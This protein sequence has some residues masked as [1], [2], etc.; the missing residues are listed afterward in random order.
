MLG[1]PA[2]GRATANVDDVLK[3]AAAACGEEG[4]AFPIEGKKHLAAN[5][6][7]FVAA[8]AYEM[9][10]TGHGFTADA[11]FTTITE[12][13]YRGATV[14][15]GW[16]LGAMLYE[17]NALP[18]H[19][20][21][22]ATRNHPRSGGLFLYEESPAGGGL[23]NAVHAGAAALAAAAAFAAAFRR[24]RGNVDPE[25]FPAPVPPASI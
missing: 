7:C 16:Q 12:T 3:A 19:Y 2:T 17:I 13:T 21:P 22:N 5:E 1:L 6:L 9:F 15:V 20:E 18:W 10:V 14:S 25:H 24:K 4:F 11:N 23:R 8:Y